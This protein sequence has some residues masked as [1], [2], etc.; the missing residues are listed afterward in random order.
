MTIDRNVLADNYYQ[1]SDNSYKSKNYRG[2]LSLDW[3]INK[4][5]R[6]GFQ[7]RYIDHKS[8][9]ILDNITN[10]NFSDAAESDM[11]V[12]TDNSED[13]YWKFGTINPYYTFQIDTLGQKIEL[14][15]NYIQYN[16]NSENILTPT[17]EIADTMMVRLKYNQPGKT[18]IIVGKLDYTY[19]FSKYLKLRVGAKYS[20]A[21]LDNNFQSKYEEAGNWV[22]NLTQSNHYL[23]DETI[24]AGYAKVS[25]TKSKWS[26]TLGLRYEDSNSRGNS[27]GV[28][29]TLSRRIKQFFPSASLSRD[30]FKGLNG[31]VAYSYRL[32]RPKYSS[33]NP[34]RYSLDAYTS[35]RGN[36]ELRPEFTHSMKFN[37]AFNKQAFFNIEYKISN[38]AIIEVVEQDDDTGEGFKSTV[39]IE[40]KKNFNM[41][42]Y[43]PLDFIPKIS[44]Y[45]G[46]IANRIH[47]KSP[48]LD[49]T[50]DKSKWDARVFH[51]EFSYKFGNRHIKSKKHK[52]GA[53]EE[54]RRADK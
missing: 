34:F 2:G 18:K 4:R 5:H 33:L 20:L 14:D 6:I 24:I 26:G 50:F 3:D 35:Q 44:G 27:V 31:T 53:S 37:L 8:D 22:P 43:F 29:T 52:S 40:S 16:S 36:P 12:R 21:D 47:Y 49:Q 54:L 7:S 25:F 13:G 30:I 42:L 38:D 19:P 41:S 9:D 1:V 28:D 39:N 45:G 48:Y 51:I 46:I 17:D 23:F 11:K 15:L 32:D 10:I